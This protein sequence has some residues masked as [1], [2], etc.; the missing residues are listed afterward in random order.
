MSSDKKQLILVIVP[1]IAV[2]VLL[3]VTSVAIMRKLRRR[4]QRA[5]LPTTEKPDFTQHHLGSLR[6]W[7]KPKADPGHLPF[8]SEPAASHQPQ[9]PV[10]GS[11]QQFKERQRQREMKAQEFNQSAGTWH[12]KP[13]GAAYWRQV[14]REMAARRTWWEKVKDNMGL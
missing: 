10:K 8:L 14:V 13:K 9:R 2:G 4:S 12:H 11:W 6:N 3:I 7:Q 5:L 1:A